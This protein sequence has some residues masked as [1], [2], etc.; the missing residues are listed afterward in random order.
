M[1]GIYDRFARDA[2]RLMATRRPRMGD[3]A[4]IEEMV[5][6]RNASFWQESLPG[7]IVSYK[8]DCQPGPCEITGRIR[9]GGIPRN[10]RVVCLHGEPKFSGMPAT[11]PV[12]V[13]WELA[14]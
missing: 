7:Q 6:A 4:L 1:S 9:Q 2:T 8:R 14:A 13:A 5:G 10:A 11:D 3:Q 12:R